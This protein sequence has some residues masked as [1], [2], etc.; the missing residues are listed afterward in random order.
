[1]VV[2]IILF[3]RKLFKPFK[4]LGVPLD[5]KKLSVP[6]WIPLIDRITG[7]LL[8]NA[9][10]FQLIKNL[11]NS[12]S[13]YWLQVFPL[14]NRVLRHIESVCRSFLWNDKEI[15]TR[16]APVARERI[17]KPKNSG[18]LNM[19]EIDIGVWRNPVGGYMNTM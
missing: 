13:S 5:S 4:Y 8:S 2:L 15:I 16:I 10:R 1:M 7:K 17:C 6:A 14:P 12:I 3:R 11:L 19:I 9:G 18:G